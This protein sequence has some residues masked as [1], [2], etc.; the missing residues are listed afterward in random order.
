MEITS[1][2]RQKVGKKVKQLRNEGLIPAVVFGNE[3]ESTSIVLDR[4]GFGKLFST[5]GETS[6]VDLNVDGEMYK[7]LINDVQFDPVSGQIIHAGF[8]KPNLKEK[9][10]VEVPVRVVGEEINPLA[11]SGAAVVLQ[12]INEIRVSALPADLPEAF[13]IDVSE[14]SEIGAHISVGQLNYDREKVEIVD[15]DEDELVVKID[16][17]TME[18]ESVEEAATE[19]DL[20]AGMEASAE[21]EAEEGEDGEDSGKGGKDKE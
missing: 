14:M 20:I 18:E 9:T 17:A 4:V 15:M 11:K 8:Y 12:L 3:I 21:K 5:A 10:E 2:K 7:V 19:A 6:L 13:V 1:Q 16:E